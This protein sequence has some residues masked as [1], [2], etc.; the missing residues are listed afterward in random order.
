MKENLKKAP[1]EA[2]V[3]E[4][5]IPAAGAATQQD[6]S[7]KPDKTLFAPASTKD[8]AF[9]VN[10]SFINLSQ[11]YMRMIRWQWHEEVEFIIINNG[12][13]L[14]KLP[15]IS[16]TLSPGDGVFIN[17]NQLHSIRTF[18]N[19]DCALFSLK[20]HPSVLF[21]YGQTSMSAKYLTPVLSSPTL[22]H[23]LLKESDSATAE[24]LGLVNDTLAC[25]MA[26]HYGYE[27]N[28]KSHL[29]SLWYLLLPFAQ[30]KADASVSL[31]SS[32]D[33]TRIK[34]ALLFIEEKHM[35]PLSLEEIA[36]AI[37]VSKSECCRC[38][39]RA[40]GITPF[41]YL[42]KFR[43]FESTRKMMRQDAE[44]KSISSL[45]ASVGFNSTSYYNKL[46]KKYLHCTPTEYMQ[47]LKNSP[48]QNPETSL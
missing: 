13:A 25:C 34:Q 36:S 45:A 40:L 1:K 11:T 30:A 42:M 2:A 33:G 44:A 12:K 16:L 21:G 39:Q 29:C 5:K 26:K 3:S 43:I 18:E 9:P 4:N 48:I 23:L 14:L 27:L 41:E 35:E 20:F 6:L 8:F 37:H 15:D 31:Q 38:F 46:F 19:E 24:I 17:Q 28:I 7:G 22:H 47:S 32:V 10:A